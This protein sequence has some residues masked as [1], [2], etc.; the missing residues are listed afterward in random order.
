MTLMTVTLMT[1]KASKHSFVFLMKLL[2]CL[3]HCF[4]SPIVGFYQQWAFVILHNLDP[5]RVVPFLFLD[6]LNDQVRIGRFSRWSLVKVL[7]IGSVGQEEQYVEVSCVIII[8][9]SMS[10]D[11]PSAR[12]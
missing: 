10:A 11:I 9:S 1:G 2:S 5:D 12:A 7:N 3:S 4:R 6:A 8:L